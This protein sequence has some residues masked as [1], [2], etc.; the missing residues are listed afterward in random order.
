MLVAYGSARSIVIVRQNLSSQAAASQAGKLYFAVASSTTLQN[1]DM[2]LSKARLML[3]PGL[4]ISAN[5][6]CLD[7]PIL[8]CVSTTSPSSPYLATKNSATYPTRGSSVRE[9]RPLCSGFH[10]SMCLERR[11]WSLTAGQEEKILPLPQP[12]LQSPHPSKTAT[13]QTY[14]LLIK[15]ILAPHPG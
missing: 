4:W 14:C 5:F 6:S 1:L 3:Q 10:Q 9:K 12:Q 15:T 11:M 8:S 7:S 13:F 2:L